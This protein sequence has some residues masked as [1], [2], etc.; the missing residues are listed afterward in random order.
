M[1]SLKVAVDEIVETA[2]DK[3]EEVGDILEETMELVN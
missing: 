2:E 3:E 1:D